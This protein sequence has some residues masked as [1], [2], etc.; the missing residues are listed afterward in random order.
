MAAK[1]LATKIDADVK[2][3]LDLYCEKHG[4]KISRFIEDAILDI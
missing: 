3:A 4:L 1:Q 2:E